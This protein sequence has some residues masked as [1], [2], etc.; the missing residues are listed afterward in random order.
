MQRRLTIWLIA[1]A[2]GGS[3]ITARQENGGMP[4]VRLMTVDPGQF[5]AG[6]VQRLAA[7]AFEPLGIAR[8]ACYRPSPTSV[9]AILPAFSRRGS[10]RAA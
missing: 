9:P 4:D 6:L 10:V 8:P 1:A 2:F 7:K 5:H 3:V